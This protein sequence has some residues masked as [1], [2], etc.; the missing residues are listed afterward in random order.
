[1][2]VDASGSMQGLGVAI[3]AVA[4]AGVVLAGDEKL[5]TSVLSFAGDVTELQPLGRRVAAEELVGRLV[6]L[7]GHGMT[8]LAGALRAARRQLAPAVVDERVVVLLSDCLHTAGDPRSP[9]WPASTPCTCC[10]RCPPRRP[11]RRPGRW[12]PVVRAGPRWSAR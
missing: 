3:A 4:A 5:T 1:M 9:R 10:A 7:R 8:D 11:R 12:P 2:V 6:S